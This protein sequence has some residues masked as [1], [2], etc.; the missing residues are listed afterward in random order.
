MKSCVDDIV[1]KEVMDSESGRVWDQ[2]W[3]IPGVEE[4]VKATGKERTGR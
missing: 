1:G 4:P 3:G 2:L